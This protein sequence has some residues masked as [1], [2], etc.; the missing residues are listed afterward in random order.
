MVK[1]IICVYVIRK[2]ASI[3]TKNK[4]TAK[5][6]C[7]RRPVMVRLKKQSFLFSF[8]FRFSFVSFSGNGTS[9]SIFV[10]TDMPPIH[11]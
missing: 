2:H 8:F 5:V 7:L 1:G 9:F 6:A 4:K 3:L 10:V 11:L